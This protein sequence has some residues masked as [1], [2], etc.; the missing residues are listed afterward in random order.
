VSTDLFVQLDRRRAY[1]LIVDQV[2][3]RI[4]R[5]MLLPGDRLAP[6]NE[7][8][9]E[10]GVSRATLRE[11]LSALEALGLV[12]TYRG[13]RSVVLEAPPEPSSAPEQEG[14]A[15]AA[16]SPLDIWEARRL[17]EPRVAA[18]AA[19]RRQDADLQALEHALEV[20]VRKGKEGAVRT[21][22]AFDF[23]LRVAQATQNPA[24]VSMLTVSSPREPTR[25]ARAMKRLSPGLE[26][27][28]GDFVRQHRAIVDAIHAGDAD[29]AFEAMDSHIL[30]II[31]DLS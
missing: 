7:L 21:P 8:C 12:Q 24:V 22:Y 11:A 30:A 14:G 1:R 15:P 18:L 10:F 3:D 26:A 16:W 29:A 25:W 20:Y 17:L 13:S 23:H 28:R 9:A 19:L 31:S 4:R 27:H 5:R 2:A 6:E